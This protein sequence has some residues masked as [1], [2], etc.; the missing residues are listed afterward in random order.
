M[1]AHSTIKVNQSRSVSKKELEKTETD[2]LEAALKAQLSALEQKK[3]ASAAALELKKAEELAERKEESDELIEKA[4]QFEKL[5]LQSTV[6]FDKNHYATE[7]L[8][9][10]KQAKEIYPEG[11][12]EPPAA[13]VEVDNKGAIWQGVGLLSLFAIAIGSFL[14]LRSWILSYNAGL[15]IENAH[16]AMPAYGWDSFQ[17][18]AFEQVV[19]VFDI[20]SLAGMLWILGP[21]ILKYLMPFVRTDNNF[22]TDFNQLSAWQRS[23]IAL[24]LLFALL[25]YLGFR[26]SVKP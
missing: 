19:T 5:S 18:I 14:G 22:S 1:N 4:Q 10:R 8:K 11:F 20:V 25:V 15:S 21:H 2:E 13:K 9:A 23:L 12:T 6:A 24:F 3:A 7:A 16:Q 26:H 17:K